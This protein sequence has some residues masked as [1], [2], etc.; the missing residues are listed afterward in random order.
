MKDRKL[1]GRWAGFSFEADFLVTPEGRRIDPTELQWMSLTLCM[2]QEWRL[3]MAEAS[4]EAKERV[5]QEVV[6]LRSR[7]AHRR[8]LSS[9]RRVHRG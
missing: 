7:L 2:A 8:R 5:S 9:P 1:T 6:T 4:Q 3:M